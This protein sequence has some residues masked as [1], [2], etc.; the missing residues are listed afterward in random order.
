MLR[1][2]PG[3]GRVVAGGRRWRGAGASG[4][5]EPTSL[6][7]AATRIRLAL[8]PIL[9]DTRRVSRTRP[10]RARAAADVSGKVPRVDV[11]GKVPRG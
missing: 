6:A 1:A 11:S 7:P 4:R 10:G 5:A 3:P 2:R 8:R 9:R